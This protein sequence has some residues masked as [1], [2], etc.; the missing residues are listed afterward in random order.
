MIGGFG[1]VLHHSIAPLNLQTKGRFQ[2]MAAHV[3]AGWQEA[4]SAVLS[5]QLLAVSYNGQRLDRNCSGA[6]SH[7]H[8]AASLAHHRCSSEKRN[9]ATYLLRK[10]WQLSQVKKSLAL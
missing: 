7:I 10:Q 1:I 8:R 3:V 5:G 6:A 9:L 2:P 4:P